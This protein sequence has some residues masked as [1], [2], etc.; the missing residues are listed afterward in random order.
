[1]RLPVAFLLC[2]VLALAAPLSSF[3]AAAKPEDKPTDKPVVPTV[4]KPRPFSWPVIKTW[5]DEGEDVRALRTAKLLGRAVAVAWCVEGRS[6]SSVRRAKTTEVPKYLIGLTVTG[7]AS[8]KDGKVTV[9]MTSKFLRK[10]Y[11]ASGL[12]APPRPPCLFLATW[13]GKFLGLIGDLRD[14][15]R[16]E[17]QK[18]IAAAAEYK[19]K[20]T[21]ADNEI[22]RLRDIKGKE[23]PNNRNELISNQRKAIKTAYVAAQKTIRQLRGAW[24][25]SVNATVRDVAKKHGRPLKKSDAR[26][27]WKSLMAARRLWHAGDHYGALKH[28][29]NVA[30]P[31]AASPS[32]E[33]AIEL[34]KDLPAINHRGAQQLEP[35]EDQYR[36]GDLDEAAAEVRRIHSAYKGFETAKNAR[37]LFDKIRAAQA[38]RTVAAK[39]A[40]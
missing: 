1:M 27:G 40:N 30:L 2:L 20:K 13:D 35:V 17:R 26:T 18:Q 7:K 32:A 14:K 24:I 28:Y 38:E 10:V 8:R 4:Q 23:V 37:A 12:G 3:A 21:A 6:R 34:A 9:A 29:R 31:V 22:K 33:L 36:R 15:Q 19:T 25:R 39:E 16:A 5:Y 11:G